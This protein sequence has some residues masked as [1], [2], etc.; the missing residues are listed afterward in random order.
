VLLLGLVSRAI[1]QMVPGAPL[2]RELAAL[3]V[4]EGSELLALGSDADGVV[5]QAYASLLPAP[6]QASARVPGLGH[7]DF[8]VS[9]RSFRFVEAA[10]A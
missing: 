2:Q 1:W 4:P 7:V 9:R 5:P 8:L 3:P 6:R 10:L